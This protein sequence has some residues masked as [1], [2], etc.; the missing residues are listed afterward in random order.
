M[1]MEPLTRTT[2]SRMAEELWDGAADGAA[3]DLPA[4]SFR[5]SSKWQR[6]LQAEGHVWLW[7]AL[8]VVDF[9]NIDLSGVMG[10]LP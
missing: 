7:N 10:S 3:G 8:D 4:A 1:S 6:R 5:T 2:S 9:I